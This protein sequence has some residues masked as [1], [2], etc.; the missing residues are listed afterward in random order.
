MKDLGDRSV[1]IAKVKIFGFTLE[2]I[3]VILSPCEPFVKKPL[4]TWLFCEEL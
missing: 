3:P 2:V 4:I 1:L